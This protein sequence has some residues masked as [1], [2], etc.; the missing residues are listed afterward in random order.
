MSDL[1]I[2]DEVR[3]F[4]DPTAESAAVENL[5]DGQ[6]LLTTKG[7]DGG[8]VLLRRGVRGLEIVQSD[9]VIAEDDTFAAA[10]RFAGPCTAEQHETVAEAIVRQVDRFS[11]A[12]GPDGGNLACVWAVRHI[13]R[14]AL[15]F[16]ITRTDGTS[17]FGGEL[18]S[19]FG[20]SSDEAAVAAGGIVISPTE[21]RNIG[22]V[23]LLGPGS[24]SD[25]LIYS[26]SSSAAR[27]KQNHTIGSWKA[28]YVD[29]KG[30]KMRFFPLPRFG[31]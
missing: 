7:E 17:V 28:R 13:V 12:E 9:N 14:D 8:Q 23:G 10:P 26:N 18:T 21:G 22:H 4:V 31:A 15:D 20:R 24:G 6:I 3:P 29:R 16:W 27:W 19:N 11:S 5:G 25:R 1:D 30:L 2:P